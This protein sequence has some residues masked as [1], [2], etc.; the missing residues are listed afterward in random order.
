MPG[1]GSSKSIPKGT[2]ATVLVFEPTTISQVTQSG[3][4]PLYT[5]ISTQRVASVRADS[6]GQFIVALPPGSYSLFVKQGKLFFANSFDTNNHINL[7]TVEEGK[8]TRVKL[9][10]NSAASY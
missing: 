4:S 5:A 8:L 2:P 1:P 9:I 6:S 10:V 3:T 7:F